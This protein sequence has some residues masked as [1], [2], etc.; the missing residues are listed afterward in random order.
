MKLKCD[1]VQYNLL[2]HSEHLLTEWDLH[3]HKVKA[4][5]KDYSPTL[6]SLIS[7]HVYLSVGK[8][9]LYNFL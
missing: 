8:Y 6:V 1:I 9:W 5:N 7:A 4:F 3:R 2:A